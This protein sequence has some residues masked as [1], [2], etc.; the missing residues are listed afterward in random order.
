MQTIKLNKVQSK[1][2]TAQL[3]YERSLLNKFQSNPKAFYSYVKSK[4][5]VKPSI[6]P[7]ENSDD[8]FIL[9]VTQRL[10]IV[11]IDILSQLLPRKIY[12]TFRYLLLVM[13]NLSD[14]SFVATELL[15]F[16]IEN[17]ILNHQQHGF[18]CNKS[19]LLETFE[20]WTSAVNQGYGVESV[21]VIYLDYSDSYK[22]FDS[23]LHRRA[24]GIYLYGYQIFLL[25][26]IFKDQ[27]MV[28]NGCLSDWVSVQVE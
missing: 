4:Q 14:P 28:V 2:R 27:R 18:V 23:V 21:D 26:N 10:L 20:D 22:V 15:N 9:P 3:S 13:R 6:S 1:L 19:N 8:S 5:K 17:S 24:H 25:Y 12:R 16:L 11:W 7:L